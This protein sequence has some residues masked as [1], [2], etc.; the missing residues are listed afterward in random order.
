MNVDRT[1]SGAIV[2]A[3]GLSRR[4]G[5][6]KALLDHEGRSFFE[7]AA[8]AVEALATE[9]SVAVVRR[10]LMPKLPALAAFDLVLVNDTPELGQLHSL[11]LALEALFAEPVGPV[12]GVY[13]LLLDNPAH[14]RERARVLKRV[15]AEDPTILMAAG[16][17]GQPGHPLWLPRRL[18]P[19]VLA[20]EGPEGLR[21]A[22]RA[23]GESIRAVETRGDSALMDIDTPEDYERL[24]GGA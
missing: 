5:R 20:Y 13:V 14:L 17:E 10:D 2:L 15:V 24:R 12:D 11:K 1:K 23:R 3:A 4:M 16:C 8:E 21:G 7:I 19:W 18:W 9:V 22:L 6:E